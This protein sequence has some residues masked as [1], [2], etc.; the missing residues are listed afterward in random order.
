[1][2]SAACSAVVSAA[3]V[4]MAAITA[5]TVNDTGSTTSLSS[6]LDPT[7]PWRHSLLQ[8]LRN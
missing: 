1:V 8:H 4:T 6:H 7:L 2:P 5:P 3:F